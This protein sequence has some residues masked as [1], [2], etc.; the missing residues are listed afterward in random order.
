MPPTQLEN[1]AEV[2]FPGTMTT[3][4]VVSWAWGQSRDCN[5][6][7]EVHIAMKNCPFRSMI[8]LS[9][10]ATFDSFRSI[11]RYQE[12]CREMWGWCRPIAQDAALCV[13]LLLHLVYGGHLCSDSE[14][15][16]PH[17]LAMG[18]VLPI[19]NM[20]RYNIY[21][22][23]DMLHML[24]YAVY[25]VEKKCSGPLGEPRQLRPAL[26]AHPNSHRLRWCL[27]DTSSGHLVLVWLWRVKRGALAACTWRF[28]W[29]QDGSRYAKHGDIYNNTSAV[30]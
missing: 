25:H 7:R 12:V 2:S 6:L 28:W 21:V 13:P 23:L 10:M 26:S 22:Y 3:R 4:N 29:L 19:K 5:S 15:F 9:N 24:I 11:L 18:R 30:N 1:Y 14:V 8:S 16:A 17:F 27:E 20:L